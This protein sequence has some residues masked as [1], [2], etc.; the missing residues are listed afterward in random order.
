MEYAHIQ[1]FLTNPA[2]SALE[3]V[4]INQE[5][6][7]FTRRLTDYYFDASASLVHSETL[8]LLLFREVR[9]FQILSLNPQ[10]SS[11]FF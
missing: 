7:D 2:H 5:T 6:T 8:N 1:A 3:Q 10:S 11:L 4:E 9:L